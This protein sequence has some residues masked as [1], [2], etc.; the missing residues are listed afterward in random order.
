MKHVP[1]ASTPFTT[2]AK[3]EEGIL[4]DS[5]KLKL[6][7]SSISTGGGGSGGSGSGG[8]PK[9]APARSRG[10]GGGGSGN[11]HSLISNGVTVRSRGGGDSEKN[12]INNIENDGS[13]SGGKDV[14]VTT[15]YNEDWCDDIFDDEDGDGGDDDGNS[16]GDVGGIGGSSSGGDKNKELDES[17]AGSGSG[18]G[19]DGD[20]DSDG[21]GDG[22]DDDKFDPFT[23]DE[24]E[25]PTPSQVPETT[26]T[27]N[28]KKKNK[29]KKRRKKRTTNT[30][31]VQDDNNNQPPLQQLQQQQQLS[32]YPCV[33]CRKF[34]TGIGRELP[35]VVVLDRRMRHVCKVKAREYFELD[36]QASV[37]FDSVRHTLV[38]G[39]HGE[40]ENTP[41]LL[42][43]SYDCI[44]E[45][46]QVTAPLQY[47][48]RNELLI[49]IIADA[50]KDN[51]Q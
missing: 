20:D 11:G 28:K 18:G 35:D 33:H 3:L 41:R 2:T 1:K 50:S 36:G 13:I 32:K 47:R 7:Q 37:D 49:Q 43:C 31:T 6:L 30:I 9:S 10:G 27:T 40:T 19:N 4:R 51:E 17:I 8:R 44:M 22:Y 25:E 34:Y 23:F 46:N 21:D 39:I 16:G 12:D 38:D 5:I 15:T 42:F 26:T 14:I 29:I 48:Y 45:W 24:E